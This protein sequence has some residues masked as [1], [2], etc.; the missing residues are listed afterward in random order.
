MF[1]NIGEK[2]KKLAIF[3]TVSGCLI[4]VVSAIVCWC[5]AI[6]WAGFTVLIIEV[7]ERE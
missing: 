7:T 5:F 6:V 4:S 3:C 2:I 1:E